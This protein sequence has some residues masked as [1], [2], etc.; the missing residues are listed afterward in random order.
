MK[1]HFRRTDFM[2]KCI[3]VYVLFFC[4]VIGL[5]ANNL[6]QRPSPARLVNDMA[7]IFSEKEKTIMENF[8][9]MVDD[10]TSN[11]ICVLT[12]TDLLDMSPSQYATEVAHEWG[13]GTKENDNGVLLLIKPKLTSSDRGEVFIAVGYGL[14]GVLTDAVCHN[15]VQQI[16]IPYF[17]QN[18]Y[19]EG[20]MTAV[21]KMAT[22][23][24]GEYS[25]ARQMENGNILFVIF[26]VV[27][28]V[29]FLII[30]NRR[31][32]G[33]KGDG[34]NPFGGGHTTYGNDDILAAMALGSLFGRG[35]RGYS[36][37]SGGFSGG[38]GGFGGGGFGGGGAGGSW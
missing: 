26:V 17:K 34:S 16:L 25:V 37:G 1:F 3:S 35:G 4:T 23:A 19:F 9:V 6:P 24:S 32:N 5:L 20:T 13:I 14:E 12:T 18:R 29:V 11:Q 8:L 21:Q 15:I 22:M 36:G 27:I 33:K 2:K 28:M 7:G 30:S 10:S 31:N 38:F